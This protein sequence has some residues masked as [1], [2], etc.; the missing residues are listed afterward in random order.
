MSD[1]AQKREG[2]FKF[3][4]PQRRVQTWR[5]GCRRLEPREVWS[6]GGSCVGRRQ[7]ASFHRREH[8]RTRP[9]AQNRQSGGRLQP[10]RI[11]FRILSGYPEV[12][13]TGLPYLDLLASIEMI[14]GYPVS[15]TETEMPTFGVAR[16]TDFQEVRDLWKNG[17]VLPLTEYCCNTV[18][19]I[20][21]L[22][23]Y[24]MKHGCIYH[25]PPESNR[26][27]RISVDWDNDRCTEQ[28]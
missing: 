10:P 11:R 14:V 8:R 19:A 27:E 5:Q 12:E 23:E 22:H 4:L 7:A 2:F 15:L 6:V 25:N 16:N 28:A 24:G 26:R 3:H 20:K 1:P 13:L 17:N 18:L 21:R 9:S